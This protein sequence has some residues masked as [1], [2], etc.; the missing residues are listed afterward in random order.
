[1]L[2]LL[3]GNLIFT[4]PTF[5]KNCSVLFSTDSTA[6]KFCLVRNE[7]YWRDVNVFIL[8]LAQI[9]KSGITQVVCQA[10]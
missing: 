8:G 3:A 10:V 9:K 6:G 1:M 4:F 2:S 7:D 5:V